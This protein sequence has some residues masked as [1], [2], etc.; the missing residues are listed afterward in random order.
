MFD[1][2]AAPAND[3]ALVINQSRFNTVEQPKMAIEHHNTL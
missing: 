3:I 2:D 1:R